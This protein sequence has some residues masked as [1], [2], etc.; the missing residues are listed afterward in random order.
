MGQ[1]FG[2]GTAGMAYLSLFHYVWGLCWE[3]FSGWGLKSFRSDTQTE[4]LKGWAQLVTVR[5]STCTWAHRVAQAS[6]VTAAGPLA[7][8]FGEWVHQEPRVERAWS[9]LTWPR[10]R[11]VSLLPHSVDRKWVTKACL[12]VGEKNSMGKWQEHV[13]KGHVRW[14][15]VVAT[16]F[17]KY[18]LPQPKRCSI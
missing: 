3:N 8:A 9:F 18:G 2:Q 15:I 7:G 5:G 10:G 12:I 11:A 4:W 6:P 1:E 14:E 13:A 16:I 17:G